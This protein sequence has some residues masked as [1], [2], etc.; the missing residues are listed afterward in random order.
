MCEGEVA[1]TVSLS[2]GDP[3]V[4]L[5]AGGAQLVLTSLH[6]R[7]LADQLRVAAEA[8][9]DLVLGRSG[10]APTERARVD[11]PGPGDE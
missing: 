4:S 2:S 10:E 5:F 6:A 8:A 3:M 11:W 9:D 1:W 7:R